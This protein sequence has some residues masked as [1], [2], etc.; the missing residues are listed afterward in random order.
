MTK[1]EPG[2]QSTVNKIT[3]EEELKKGE[4]K[5]QLSEELKK[6]KKKKKRK[7][8]AKQEPQPHN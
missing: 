2:K 5:E 4:G 1:Y 3:E 8:K 6:K 7:K